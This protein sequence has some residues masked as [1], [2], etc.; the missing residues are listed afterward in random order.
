MRIK[1]TNSRLYVDLHTSSGI[2]HYL[3]RQVS[4]RP[5]GEESPLSA[6]LL[7]VPGWLVENFIFPASGADV[8]GMEITSAAA[9]RPINV[10]IAEQDR[11][12]PPVSAT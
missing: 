11:C 1:T 3:F 8:A 4:V 2:S 7:Y 10:Y 6:Y 5:T 9:D 12:R